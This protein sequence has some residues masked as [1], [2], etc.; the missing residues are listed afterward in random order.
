MIET[1][2]TNRL[3]II[4]IN[5]K[6][7]LPYKFYTKQIRAYLI[8]ST[9]HFKIVLTKSLG[10]YK[11]KNV[12]KA[13]EEYEVITTYNKG[14]ILKKRS[15][16]VEIKHFKIDII[17]RKILFV[18]KDLITEKTRTF[19]LKSSIP[20][21]IQLTTTQKRNIENKRIIFKNKKKEFK[22]GFNKLL[23]EKKSFTNSLKPKNLV[24]SFMVNR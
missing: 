3:K 24:K 10:R 9:E 11:F 7:L 5:N 8:N 22:K 20:K 12:I 6:V 23:N 4:S 17:N 18:T 19:E 2:T 16:Y 14:D 21:T 13:N 1:I 15:S